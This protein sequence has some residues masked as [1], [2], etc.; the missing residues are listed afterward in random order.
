MRIRLEAHSVPESLPWNPPHVVPP[1]TKS[2]CPWPAEDHEALRDMAAAGVATWQIA[3]VLGR[4]TSSVEWQAHQLG[5][6]LGTEKP[7]S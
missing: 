6:S 7:R 1:A 3:T 5:L 2:R 4:S